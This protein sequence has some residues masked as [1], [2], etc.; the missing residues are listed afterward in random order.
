MAETE[1]DFFSDPAVIADP[2]SYL[3]QMREKCPVAKE[4][5]QGAYMVPAMR[6]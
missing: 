1:A 2:F 3:K 6:R 4:R 5:H